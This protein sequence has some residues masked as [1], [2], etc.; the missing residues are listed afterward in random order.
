MQ[1]QLL[2]AKYHGIR[3]DQSMPLKA[4]RKTR[5]TT[6]VTYLKSVVL[7]SLNAATR[8]VVSCSL[9][10]Y[11]STAA[12]AYTKS[13]ADKPVKASPVPCGPSVPLNKRDLNK[14][15]EAQISSIIAEVES[16]EKKGLY[17]KAA[18]Q[19]LRAS[20]IIAI[21]EGPCSVNSGRFKLV[22]GSK[23][24][25]AFRLEA[26]ENHLK[27]GLGILAL[28][29]S[30][31]EEIC[32]EFTGGLQFLD[33]IYS[34]KLDHRSLPAIFFHS[35]PFLQNCLRS[36]EAV[37]K[38]ALFDVLIRL[39]SV[40][41]AG[42]GLDES[43]ALSDERAKLA[44]DALN[45]AYNV[46]EGKPTESQLADIL[47]KEGY[48]KYRIAG[49]AN[50]NKRGD[51]LLRAK[52]A[53]AQAWRIH[54]GLNQP[55]RAEGSAK[56]LAYILELLGDYAQAHDIY[57][58][59]IARALNGPLSATSIG[60]NYSLLSGYALFAKNLNS[61]T[62]FR[63][64]LLMLRQW[65]YLALKT[66]LPSMSPTERMDYLNLFSQSE[67]VASRA[68]AAG[69]L[70]SEEYLDSFLQLRYSLIESELL[71]LKIK[72]ENTSSL[73]TKDFGALA[74]LMANANIDYTNQIR[75]KLAE[76]EL[77]IQFIEPSPQ[78]YSSRISTTEIETK[79]QAFAIRGG[80]QSETPIAYKLCDKKLC[81]TL[82]LD[83]LRSSSEGLADAFGKWVV[84]L[85]NLISSAL[86]KEIQESDLIYIG[87]DGYLQRVPIG[88]LRVYLESK[89][90]GARRI[91]LVQSIADLGSGDRRHSG[92]ASTVFYSPEFGIGANCSFNQYCREHWKKLV[93]STEEGKAVSEILSARELSG[94]YATKSSLLNATSPKVLHISSHAGFSDAA[95]PAL[96]NASLQHGERQVLDGLYNL[97]IVA[98]GANVTPAESSILTYEDLANLD[99]GG[100]ALVVLSACETGLGGSQ[101]GYGLFGMHRILSS[102]G[103]DS[104]LLSMW[105]VD[106]EATSV[107]MI[108]F[109]NNLKN[110]YTVD[111]ALAKAQD[112][113]IKDPKLASRGWNH[114]YYWAG[115]Q[116]AGKM[117]PVFKK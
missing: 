35:W 30:V 19:Y 41:F 47:L 16:L 93:Y 23:L 5:R 37:T 90:L 17:E 72:T 42:Y 77:F 20:K 91:V 54:L 34:K 89:S 70:S 78:G 43:E 116:I 44:F 62:H 95:N 13:S 3:I 2:M 40:F 8:I 79:N 61:K 80:Y 58:G 24:Y 7:A 29:N 14:E 64:A 110:G 15:E 66:L 10:L 92:A 1:Q 26:A 21:A 65:E 32:E 38:P 28:H 60:E 106:D 12:A 113:M 51:L 46:V 86:I 111:E 56:Q 104:T 105:K 48:F 71:A 114:P 75:T 9:I 88:I 84:L 27:E 39:S 55:E 103:A 22:Y 73:A 33:E 117:T 31:T 99:L 11:Y 4:K 76:N 69:I 97:Y 107:L 45:K 102:L 36:Q 25:R 63:D 52:D 49:L 108:M 82:L 112:R 87:L 67:G 50:I 96:L 57:R 6:R 94:I 59:L 68:F 18:S 101:R 98:S 74:T 109:Y 53:T 100:T 115:W 83:A 85:D 81:D